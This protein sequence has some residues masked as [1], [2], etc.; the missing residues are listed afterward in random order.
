MQLPLS[1]TAIPIHDHAPL[2]YTPKHP[3]PQQFLC[4]WKLCVSF[5]LCKAQACR[6]P[7]NFLD[8]AFVWRW[9]CLG[10]ISS[11]GFRYAKKKEYHSLPGRLF[12]RE[13]SAMSLMM[14][15]ALDTTIFERYCLKGVLELLCASLKLEK[16]GSSMLAYSVSC[17]QDAHILDVAI[18]SVVG[19]L[20]TTETT[21]C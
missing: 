16:Q 11:G 13:H 5:S 3:L 15:S 6:I 12:W 19:I 4:E 9:K 14:I 21:I 8:L 20:P 18:S 2:L 17:L 7:T 10:G 1:V